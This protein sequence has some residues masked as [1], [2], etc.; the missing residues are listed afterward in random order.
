MNNASFRFQLQQVDLAL[1]ALFQERARLC[2]K[3]G[4][5]ADEV[6]MEDLLRRADGSVPAEVIRAVFEKLNQ[7]SLS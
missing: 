4:S 6:A 5:V 7:G 2:R 1:L 3:A